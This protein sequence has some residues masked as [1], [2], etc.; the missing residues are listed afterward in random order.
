MA[1]KKKTRKRTTKSKAPKSKKKD[2][3]PQFMVQLNEPIAI[4]REV[5]ES[6]REVIVFMQGHEKFLRVQ[7][8]K[9]AMI[10]K[11]KTDVSSINVLIENRLRK[12]LPTG[13]LQVFRKEVDEEDIPEE[14]PIKKIV[15]PATPQ[16]YT[17]IKQPVTPRKMPT[18]IEEMEMQLRDIENQLKGIQ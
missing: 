5:L 13:K 11:L 9:M 4:R 1:K 14:K 10:A 16:E 3:E 8:E 18:E 17:E 15:A 6:L 2:K 12:F 7:E